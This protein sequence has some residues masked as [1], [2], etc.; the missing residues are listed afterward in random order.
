MKNERFLHDRA[1]VLDAPRARMSTLLGFL[2][3]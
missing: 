1:V 3:N 2:R